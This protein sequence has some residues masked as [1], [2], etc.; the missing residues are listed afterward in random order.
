MKE[1]QTSHDFSKK[2]ETSKIEAWK[3]DKFIIPRKAVRHVETVSL[4]LKS[5][6][7]EK[8]F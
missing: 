5:Q 8:G 3:D 1:I 4:Q 6:T 2:E 7:F